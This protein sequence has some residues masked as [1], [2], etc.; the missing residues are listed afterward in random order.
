METEADALEQATPGAAWKKAGRLEGE[1]QVQGPGA[2]VGEGRA[3]LESASKAKRGLSPLQPRTE[4]GVLESSWA[5]IQARIQKILMVDCRI[6][7][8]SH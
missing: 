1:T 6:E 4:A 7:A 8:L 2:G 3:H 5:E